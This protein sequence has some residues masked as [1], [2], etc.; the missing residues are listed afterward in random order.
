M[1]SSNVKV[2]SRAK[3][4][5]RTAGELKSMDEI[6]LDGHRVIVT[7]VVDH[8]TRPGHYEISGTY[9]KSGAL[10]RTGVTRVVSAARKFTVHNDLAPTP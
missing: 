7:A 3:L 8:S 1:E 10:R 6:T 2:K 9:Q 4:P 5:R